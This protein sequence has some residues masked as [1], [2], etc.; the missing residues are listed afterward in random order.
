MTDRIWQPVGARLLVM[1]QPEPRASSE[2]LI[3]P[4]IEDAKPSKFATVVSVGDKVREAIPVGATV[5]L[6]DYS[7]APCSVTVAGQDFEA[8]MVDEKDVLGVLNV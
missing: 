8:H 3:L 5:I 7:G 2:L 6:S 4:E 1:R